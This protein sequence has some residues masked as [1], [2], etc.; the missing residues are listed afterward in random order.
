MD[1]PKTAILLLLRLRALSLL[2]S[3]STDSQFEEFRGG[4]LSPLADSPP[5]RRK[6]GVPSCVFLLSKGYLR[7]SRVESGK[8]KLK[9]FKRTRLSSEV[10]E[11]VLLIQDIL[12]TLG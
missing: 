2:T 6:S 11:E 8:F 5:S 7:E 3:F 10:V 12:F 1:S 9:S 4:V